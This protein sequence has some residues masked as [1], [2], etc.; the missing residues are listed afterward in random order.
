MLC[1]HTKGIQPLGQKKKPHYNCPPSVSE[2]QRA[3]ESQYF[4]LRGGKIQENKPEQSEML[5]TKQREPEEAKKKKRSG[6]ILCQQNP[7][8]NEQK[9]Q[10]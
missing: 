4:T 5:E 3:E 10:N 8:M 6:R 9:Y 2:T 1:L 7:D